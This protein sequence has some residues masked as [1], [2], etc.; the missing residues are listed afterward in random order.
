MQI[1]DTGLIAESPVTLLL[2]IAL[3]IKGIIGVISVVE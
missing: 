3:G 1:F 2:E